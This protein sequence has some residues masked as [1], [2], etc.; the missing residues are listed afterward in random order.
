MSSS[1]LGFIFSLL[2]DFV[3]DNGKLCVM[4]QSV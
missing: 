2:G 4:T 1:G 3:V